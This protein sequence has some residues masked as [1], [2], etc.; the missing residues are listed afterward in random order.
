MA[1]TEKG[2]GN[3]V[4]DPQKYVFK[5]LQSAMTFNCHWNHHNG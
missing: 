3:A 1:L 2:H 5:S 4:I